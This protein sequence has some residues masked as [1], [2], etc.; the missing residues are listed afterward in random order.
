MGSQQH[1]VADHLAPAAYP[2]Q[3]PPCDAVWE[4]TRPDRTKPVAWVT[5]DHA[6]RK[7]EL[8]EH[9]EIPCY[10]DVEVARVLQRARASGMRNVRK[11]SADEYRALRGAQ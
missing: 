3:L 6:H 8:V 4:A 5:Y 11:L 9:D 7:G 2:T 1:E 10:N